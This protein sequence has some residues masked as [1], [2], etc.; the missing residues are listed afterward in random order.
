M[1]TNVTM[2][3]GRFNRQLTVLSKIDTPDG[4]GGFTVS[5]EAQETVWAEI[6][7]LKSVAVAGAGDSDARTTLYRIMIR[8][9]PNITQQSQFV[10]GS[11]KFAVQYLYDPDETRR[12]L[13]CDCIEVS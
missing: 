3:A 10:T 6:C 2:D 11:R 13:Q 4:C 5:Y 1:N 9:R 8:Y 12:Y 7:P